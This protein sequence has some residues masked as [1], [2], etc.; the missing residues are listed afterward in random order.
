MTD[1]TFKD[2]VLDQLAG[3]GFVEA[4]RMFG[5]YGIYADGRFFAIL[6]GD[7]LYFKTTAATRGPYEACGMGPFQAS[8]K[9]VLKNYYEVPG[10]VIDDRDRL[11]DWARGAVAIASPPKRRPDF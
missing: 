4:R 2:F 10:D 1:S 5:A 9:Q 11:Q 3:L 7:R 8:E 6:D